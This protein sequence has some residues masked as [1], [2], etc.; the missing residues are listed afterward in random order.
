MSPAFL[1]N[2]VTGMQQFIKV[3]VERLFS[4]VFFSEKTE[5]VKIKKEHFNV[6][7]HNGPV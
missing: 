5:Y 3:K 2:Y 1:G 4:L 7:V 6:C